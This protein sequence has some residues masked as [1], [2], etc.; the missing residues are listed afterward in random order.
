MW[1]SILSGMSFDIK[2]RTW[3]VMKLYVG[4]KTFV[5]SKLGYLMQTP[6]TIYLIC[7]MNKKLQ[8]YIDLI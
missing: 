1:N 4:L 7:V 8:C 6:H 2:I 3:Q 5:T